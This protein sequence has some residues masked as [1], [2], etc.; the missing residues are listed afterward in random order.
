[1]NNNQELLSLFS[2]LIS[3]IQELRIQTEF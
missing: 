2:L 1:M 3:P